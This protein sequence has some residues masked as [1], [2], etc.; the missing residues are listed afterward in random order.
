M[1]MKRV[2]LLV[3]LL[4]LPVLAACGSNTPTPSSAPTPTAAPTLAPGS[5]TYP[6]SD[7]A[8]NDA[9]SAMAAT[10]KQYGVTII[11]GH[12][13]I[14]PDDRWP[15]V[16]NDT[17]GALSASQ[18]TAIGEAVM[19]VQVLASWADEHRQI[20]LLPHMMNTLFVIGTSGVALAEGT[21][22][23]S[24]DC[25]TY[26]TELAVHA[27]S[28]ALH[29]ALV[30]SGQNIGAAA[31]PVVMSFDGPCTLT[32][33]TKSGDEVTV[34]T[35]PAGRIVAMVTLKN[36]PVLGPIGHLDGAT[37]CDDP[38]AAPICAG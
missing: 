29:D 22:V 5:D 32:G 35:I 13:T 16:G 21:S 15:D 26:P 27:P 6:S 38:N 17:G 18:A 24:P 4:G 11:P 9:P 28:T 1:S 8:V 31:L 7:T 37:S 33:T 20:S 36:D 2:A 30:K 23:H 19:R 10:W 14:D 3:A 25:S 34:D 12:E